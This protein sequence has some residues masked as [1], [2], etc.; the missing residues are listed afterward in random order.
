MST[1]LSQAHNQWANRPADESFATLPEL[2]AAVEART[3]RAREAREVPYSSLRV[4]ADSGDIKLVGKANV[5]ASFTH[6][7]FGQLSRAIGAPAGYLR[8]LPAT[9][10][11]QNMNHGLATRGADAGECKLLLDVNGSYAVRAFTGPDYSRI[12][13]RDITSR[14]LTLEARGWQP[15]PETA[16]ANGGTTRGLYASDHD[17]FLFLVDN[18]RRVFESMPGGG[19]SRG[20]MIA[21]SETGDKSFWLLSFLYAYI[22]GNHNIWGVEGVK[23]L[24]IRHTGAA[25]ERAFSQL[26][27]ELRAY[28]DASASTDESRIRRCMAHELGAD[29]DEV[30]D[31]LFALKS[32]QLSRKLLGDAYQAAEEHSDWYGSPR[33]AWGLG[34]GLSEMARAIPHADERVRVERAAGKVF[35]MAF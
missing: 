26:A 27:V 19:L 7:S 8:E 10:A 24:R 5:P 11:A 23:E 18:S 32:L 29:K 14:A 3:A 9:L 6:W 20:V 16:L 4:Q 28:A 13:D 17:V 12:W 35:E 1:V 33:S 31:K 21:N 30:L 2:H 25:D 15:A 22:C 34:N